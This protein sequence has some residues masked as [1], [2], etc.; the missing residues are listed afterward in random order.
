MGQ[1]PLLMKV[2][3]LGRGL[4]LVEAVHGRVEWLNRKSSSTGYLLFIFLVIFVTEF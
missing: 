4:R 3:G 2:G 1:E